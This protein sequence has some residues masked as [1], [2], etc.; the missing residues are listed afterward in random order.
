MSARITLHCDTEWRYGGCPK[1]LLTDARTLDEARAAARAN[2]WITHSDGRDMCAS[3]SG[4]GP[5]PAHAVVAVLH[6]K[7]QP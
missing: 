5:Q 4:R 2:G 6:P 3:C 7:E 1:Q